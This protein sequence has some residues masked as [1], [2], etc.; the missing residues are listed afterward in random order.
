MAY[1]PFTHAIEPDIY[2]FLWSTTN[3]WL[4]AAES[5][6]WWCIISKDYFNVFEVVVVCNKKTFRNGGRGRWRR[7][8]IFWTCH[9]LLRNGDFKCN[10]SEWVSHGPSL[11]LK[12]TTSVN[13]VTWL[14]CYAFHNSYPKMIVD[15]CISISKKC[16]NSICYNH[17]WTIFIIVI[18]YILVMLA[19]CCQYHATLGLEYIAVAPNL[20]HF[21]DVI[22]ILHTYSLTNAAN[23]QMD[24]SLPW[25][26]CAVPVFG[27]HYEWQPSSYQICSQEIIPIVLARTIF[28]TWY[29]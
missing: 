15:C 5:N 17:K 18:Y 14:G 20:N 28:L 19:G 13:H 3:W 27:A 6:G 24:E 10:S 16:V 4:R 26:S 22:T 12:T 21:F 8:L 29:M 2:F 9:F 7:I 11:R 23:V 1:I 25:L